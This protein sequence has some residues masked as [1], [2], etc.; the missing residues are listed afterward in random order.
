MRL[1]EELYLRQPGADLREPRCTAVPIPVRKGCLVV[2]NSLLFHANAPNN[3]PNFRAVQYIRGMPVEGKA[4]AISTAAPAKAPDLYA[5]RVEVPP[6]EGGAAHSKH[7]YSAM[8]TNPTYYPA[9][10]Q[11]TELGEKMFGV[12]QWDM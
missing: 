10:F 4:R 2:W 11:M 1:P 6:E 12:K 8:V 5:L 3:S 9:D 7:P